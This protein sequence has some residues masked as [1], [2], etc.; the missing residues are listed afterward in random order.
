MDWSDSWRGAFRIELRAQAI[1]LAWRGWQVMPGTYPAGNQWVGGSGRRS[2]VPT[3]VFEDWAQR[4]DTAPAG[5]IADWWNGEPYSLLV[6]TGKTLDAIEVGDDLGRQTAAVLRS[7][8][9]PVPI[10][11]TPSGRWL[12]LVE[13]GERLHSELAASD[14]VILHSAG[15]WIPLPPSAFLSGIVHWRVRP[16]VCGWDLPSSRIVQDALLRAVPAK[17]GYGSLLAA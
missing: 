1:G 16:E 10:A 7:T 12:F 4:V 3:P 13:A 2:D 9:F 6:A 5:E 15:S 11:A 8:G 14:D 17:A